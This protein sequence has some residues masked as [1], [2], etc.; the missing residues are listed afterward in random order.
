MERK[1]KIFKSFEEQEAYNLE[2]MRKTTPKERFRRLYMM[3]QMSRRFH[4]TSDNIRKITIIRNGPV[5]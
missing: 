5:E 1:I 4:P 3:Q 2:Q